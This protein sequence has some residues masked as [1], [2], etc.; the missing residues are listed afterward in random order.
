[1]ETL[2]FRIEGEGLDLPIVGDV[3][4]PA[5]D[6]PRPVVVLAHGWLGWKDWGYLPHLA[7]ALAAAGLVAVTF[8]F[9][10]SGV[11]AGA[12]EIL[13]V[14]TFARN[15]W[16]REVRDQ[17]R[18][19]TAI[20]ERMLPGAARFDIYR[21]GALGA[22]TGGSVTLLE[23][24]D[25]SRVRAVVTIGAPLALDSV[26]PSD[27]RE[28]YG[29]RGELRFRDPR[30]NR[31]LRIDAAFLRDLRMRRVALDVL[32]AAGK[33]PARYLAIHGAADAR[34]PLRDAKALFFANGERG[35][36][37]VVPGAG[38][39][40]DVEHPMGEPGDAVGRARE[41]A[42]SFFLTKLA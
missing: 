1:M 31:A 41:A 4:L 13:D 11:P 32:A 38:A 12:D 10:G 15:T 27:A 9:S 42:V 34:V 5:G 18:V 29:A 2:A 28:A 30:S 8:S 22:G 14:E 39:D 6:E 19:V 17:A 36:I 35:E 20:F 3:R 25:D 26:L 33:M 24:A 7:E 40:L 37:E 21:I 23:A 16:S